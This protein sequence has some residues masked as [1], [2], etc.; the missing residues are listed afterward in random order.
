M[1][2]SASSVSSVTL[3]K[4]Q[5]L[6]KAV[7]EIVKNTNEV[8]VKWSK[9]SWEVKSALD[10]IVKYLVLSDKMMDGNILSCLPFGMMALRPVSDSSNPEV[11][12]ASLS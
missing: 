9:G 7:Q 3:K 1:L 11:V 8:F 12:L 10:S 5:T 4:G 6:L 2:N